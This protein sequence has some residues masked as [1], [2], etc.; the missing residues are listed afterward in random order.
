MK[1][2]P[3]FFLS[4]VFHPISDLDE[5]QKWKWT[6][7]GNQ[8]EGMDM[9]RKADNCAMVDMSMTH[10]ICG[11]LTKK[12]IKATALFSSRLHSIP[13]QSSLYPA[14]TATKQN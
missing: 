3:F 7:K 10:S 14:T 9:M 12:E 8:M 13:T 5:P 11:N 2:E 6:I 1:Y 4:H